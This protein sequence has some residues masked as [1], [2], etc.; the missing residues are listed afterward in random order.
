LIC[1][2]SSF[3]IEKLNFCFLSF[4]VRRLKNHSSF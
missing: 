2:W 3:C 4:F 1:Q